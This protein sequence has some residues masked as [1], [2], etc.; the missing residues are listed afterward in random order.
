VLRSNTQAKRDVIFGWLPG[1][2]TDR[3]SVWNEA[4]PITAEIEE[5]QGRLKTQVHRIGVGVIFTQQSGVE[6]PKRGLSV[7]DKTGQSQVLLM[8]KEQR[9]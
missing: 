6:L 9:R 1:L 5:Y 8:Q 3:W 2:K 4:A 7:C